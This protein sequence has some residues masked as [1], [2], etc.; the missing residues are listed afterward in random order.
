LVPSHYPPIRI[1]EDLL[2]PAELEA[3]YELEGYTNDRVRD[4]VGDITLVPKHDRI[5]GLGSTPIMAAFTHTGVPSRFTDGRYGIY[6]AGLDIQT[7]LKEA[8]QSRI[9]FLMAT[10]EKAQQVTLRCYQCSVDA[11]LVDARGQPELHN[12]ED[13]RAAQ[14]FGARIK[15]DDQYGILY[16]SVRN[17]GG[18]CIAALRPTAMVPPANQAGHY[19]LYWDGQKIEQAVELREVSI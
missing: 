10:E 9:R 17:S 19:Q 7:A 16:H 12:P 1:F 6:Y 4:E 2:D 18:E 15:A 11:I 13:W 3:A 8:V 14:D 5:V